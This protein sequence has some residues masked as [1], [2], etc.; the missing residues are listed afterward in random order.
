MDKEITLEVPRLMF[1][2]P[3]SWNKKVKNGVDLDT[4]PPVEYEVKSYCYRISTSLRVYQFG[5]D[6]DSLN[7]GPGLFSSG[8][9]TIL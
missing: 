7:H 4:C 6:I 1:G 9:K 5:I 8:P 2:T 3:T